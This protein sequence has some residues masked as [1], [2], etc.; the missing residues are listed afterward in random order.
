MPIFMSR[1]Q[2]TTPR[3]MMR[4][5]IGEGDQAEGRKPGMN[6][7]FPKSRRFPNGCFAQRRKGAKPGWIKNFFPLRLCGFARKI[8]R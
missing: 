7:N 6:A 1:C 3:P 5:Q 2:Q 4:Y 8:E